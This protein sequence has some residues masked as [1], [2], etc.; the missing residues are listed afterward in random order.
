MCVAFFV[1]T[2]VVRLLYDDGACSWA[3]VWLFLSQ[4]SVSV[5]ASLLLLGCCP[6]KIK[7]VRGILKKKEEDCTSS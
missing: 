6:S 2:C 7:H 3:H 1:S 5:C 4:V